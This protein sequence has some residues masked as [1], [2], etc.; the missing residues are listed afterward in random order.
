L[1]RNL[2]RL[3]WRA[4]AADLYPD[5]V[6]IRAHA[7][8]ALLAALV[9]L[10]LAGC[11]G[12]GGASSP[13][14]GGTSVPLHPIAGGFKPN[15]V[16]LADCPTATD[17]TRCVEQA[18][19]N[20]AFREGPKPALRLLVAEMAAKP[21]V[22]RGCHRIVHTIGSASLARQKGN[23]GRAFS[24]GDSTCWSGY[25]HGILE[26]A[27]I[28][29]KNEVLLRAAVRGVCSEVL[30][31]EPQFISY[32]CVHGLGHGLMILTGLNL[33]K[34]LEHCEGLGTEWEQVSCD[35]GVFMENFNTSYGVTSRYVKD[36]DL[37]YPCNDVAERHKLY[38][39]LQITDRLL[40]QTGYDWRRAAELC[41]SAEKAWRATCFQSFG[42]SASGTARLDRQTLI[43]YCS[44][45]EPRW[46][47][48]CV[49][50]A[51]RDITSNDAA[52]GRAIAFCRAVATS[53]QARCFYGLGTIVAG[54]AAGPAELAKTCAGVPARYRPECRLER[55]AN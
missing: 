44:V 39:Y 24:E 32:Q 12:D 3:M 18:F 27:L 46:R 10:A 43:G 48:E 22:E 45:P 9:L 36:D 14:G 51:V 20:L 28:D 35:G 49:Y 8:L 54:F 26:R 52:P 29:A 37:L 2:K 17:P 6:S 40:G 33:P 38:C 7:L 42:R 34:S 30:R 50:G 15:S 53:L 31:D 41:A 19:G 4:D 16:A 47:G 5:A 23:V 25:Y 11:G 13:T 55:A 21:E 1:S